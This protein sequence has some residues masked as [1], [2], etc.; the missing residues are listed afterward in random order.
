MNTMAE[1]EKDL[2]V[3]LKKGDRSALKILFERYY[4]NLYAFLVVKAKNI[5]EAEDLLQESMLRLWEKREHIDAERPLGPYLK[6]LAFNL[7][8]SKKRHEKV[9]TRFI[10][11]Q[12]AEIQSTPVWD[13]VDA[14]DAALLDWLKM[15]MKELPPLQQSTL[16]MHRYEGLS[17]EEIATYLEL[18]EKAIQKRMTKA[19]KLL[20]AC[21][22]RKKEIEEL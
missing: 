12:L 19:F 4:E 9:A 6:T 5:A 16:I 21:I 7:F 10:D 22:K 20:R 8:I 2:I 13:R 3:R 11:Q 18:S 17:Y 14:E 1:T 15:C